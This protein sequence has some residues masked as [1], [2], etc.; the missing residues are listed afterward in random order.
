MPQD[1]ACSILETQRGIQF[2]P[3]IVDNFLAAMRTKREEKK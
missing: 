3:E 2:D 1:V